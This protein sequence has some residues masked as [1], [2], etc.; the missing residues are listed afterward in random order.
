MARFDGREGPDRRRRQEDGRERPGIGVSRQGV[1]ERDLVLRMLKAP[2]RW[3]LG[4]GQ[5]PRTARRVD[6]KVAGFRLALSCRHRAAGEVKALA[7]ASA[8]SIGE[9]GFS[10][11]LG[12]N[13]R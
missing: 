4:P 7:F 3:S 9:G 13:G 1:G 12:A 11:P 8:Y 10:L 2:G 5:A 6:G